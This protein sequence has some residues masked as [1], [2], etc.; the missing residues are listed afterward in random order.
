MPNYALIDAE[1]RESATF[2]IPSEVDRLSVPVGHY[3]KLMFDAGIPDVPVERMWV[4][5]SKKTEGAFLYEGTLAN[6]P[7]FIP[8]NVL[9]YT[10]VVRFSPNHIISIMEP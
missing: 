2:E 1:A 9:K 4:L 7:A 10:D 6:D 5:V 3:A 8:S